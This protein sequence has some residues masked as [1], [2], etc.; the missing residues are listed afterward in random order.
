[1]TNRHRE[2]EQGPAFANRGEASLTRGRRSPVVH[3]G[4]RLG[5]ETDCAVLNA[6]HESNRSALRNSKHLNWKGKFG[7]KTE[8]EGGGTIQFKRRRNRFCSL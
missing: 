8:K 5:S 4:N 3:S 7:F 6:E 1:M 2:E